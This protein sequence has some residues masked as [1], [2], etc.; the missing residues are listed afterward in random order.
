MTE[1]IETPEK[2]DFSTDPHEAV[3]Q[4]VIRHDF[5]LEESLRLLHGNKNAG[6]GNFSLTLVIDGAVVSGI[7][8]SAGRWAELATEQW[9]GLSQ[10]IGQAF[11]ETVE[12]MAKG[13]E[14]IVSS[15]E[16]EG[17]PPIAWNYIHMR[18]VTINPGPSAISFPLWR[19][20]MR[21][22]SGWSLG[23]VNEVANG[24]NS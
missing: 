7:A 2:Y 9:T 4:D 16:A 13:N 6:A 10:Q 22:I 5:Y 3:R 21:H 12:F 20:K 1:A 8:I 14:E 23:S 17:R 11:G 24:T 15:R 19:G 18:D